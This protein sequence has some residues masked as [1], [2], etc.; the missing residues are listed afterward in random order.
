MIL[1]SRTPFKYVFFLTNLVLEFGRNYCPA[2]VEF[3]DGVHGERVDNEHECEQNTPGDCFVKVVRVT[4]E[5]PD[6]LK[7]H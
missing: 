4:R 2:A 7:P 5:P 6:A 1:A 3:P